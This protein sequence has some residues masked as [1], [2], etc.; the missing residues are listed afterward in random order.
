MKGAKG[1]TALL[2]SYVTVPQN[3][4]YPAC[5]GNTIEYTKTGIFSEVSTN[6]KNEML[7]SWAAIDY[8]DPHDTYVCPGQPQIG[9]GKTNT[10]GFDF[11]YSKP[12]S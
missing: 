12:L 4:T 8:V 1:S 2:S 3:V 6:G 5:G 9:D 7:F 11:L 10:S